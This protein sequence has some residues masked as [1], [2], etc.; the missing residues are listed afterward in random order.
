MIFMFCPFYKVLCFPVSTFVFLFTGTGRVTTVYFLFIQLQLQL[1]KLHQS[2]AY[3]HLNKHD[4]LT[5]ISYGYS[6]IA[7]GY[8]EKLI[9]K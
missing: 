5:Y 9:I 6:I 7:I 2:E 3:N 1:I 8:I 4:F